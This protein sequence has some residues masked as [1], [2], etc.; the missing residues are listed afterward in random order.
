MTSGSSKQ[1]ECSGEGY[2]N[3]AV[4]RA[5]FAIGVLGI[6]FDRAGGHHRD[7]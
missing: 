6:Q 5:E 3:S 4:V 7:L 2:S 1:A